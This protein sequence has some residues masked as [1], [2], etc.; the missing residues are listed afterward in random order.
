MNNNLDQN[1]IEVE[2]NV[3][4]EG[5]TVGYSVSLIEGDLRPPI[6]MLG[7]AF[8]NERSW[9]PIK[10]F[11]AGRRSTLSLSLPGSFGNGV[12]P[13]DYDFRWVARCIV[14][15]LDELR[16]ER[17]DLLAFSYSTP[18]GFCLASGHPDRVHRLALGGTTEMFAEPI[19]DAVKLSIDYIEKGDI[20]YFAAISIGV[21]L[22]NCDPA[23]EVVRRDKLVKLLWRQ[24]TR[25]TD[26]ETKAYVENTWRVLGMSDYL[27]ELKRPECL[28][29]GFTG[30]HDVLTPA[31]DCKKL[32]LGF[33]RAI[34]TTIDKTDHL[35]LMEDPDTTLELVD[36]FFNDATPKQVAGCAPYELSIPEVLDTGQQLGIN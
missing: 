21:G 24:L 27:R 29:L 36:T 33:P 28:T 10:K 6:L 22:I 2:G 1:T 5:F 3:A 13:R 23:V 8:Q 16:I 31:D 34:F 14:H 11:F 12:L 26:Q 20:Q 25:L 9:I 32:I 35:F 15:V 18:A 7:G 4:F 17:V 30:I 19:I